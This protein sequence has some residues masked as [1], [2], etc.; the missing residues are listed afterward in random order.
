M[1]ITRRGVSASAS[2]IA[3]NDITLTYPVTPN[4]GDVAL[5]FVETAAQNVNTPSGYSISPG[6]PVSVGSPGVAGGTQL[7]IFQRVC[8]GTE[9]ATVVV[10]SSSID[11]KI[12]VVAVYS[13]CDTTT[14]VTASTGKTQ[15]PASTTGSTNT[16]AS[17][18]GDGSDHFLLC[19]AHDRDAS[20]QSSASSITWS[21]IT[22]S[23]NATVTN[24]FTASNSGGGLLV[25]E[26]TPSGDSTGAVSL[27]SIT[28]TSTIWASL[29]LRLNAAVPSSPFVAPNPMLP[30]LVR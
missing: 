11:H 16:I 19:M 30:L 26:G 6:S 27:S 17:L 13:G 25:I 1:A 7:N 9:G 4:V 28:I 24:S 21:N 3:A 23:T 29:L 5:I 12:G 20:S 22:M 14:P 15:T 18:A 10:N 2:S 8:D